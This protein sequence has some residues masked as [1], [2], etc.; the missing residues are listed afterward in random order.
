M[1]RDFEIR[2]L[3]AET[4]DAAGAAFED[5]LRPLGYR[6]FDAASMNAAKLS[7][8]KEAMRFF[9]CNYYDGDIWKYFPKGWPAGDAPTQ[10]LFERTTPFDYVELLR[11]SEQTLSTRFQLGIL[12]LYNVRRA[13]I[14]P[15]ST[16]SNL[17]FVT[18][19]M[20]GGDEES[21]ARTRDRLSIIASQLLNR[22]VELHKGGE[23]V[24]TT[25]VFAGLTAEET[26]CL[27]ALSRGLSNP[28]IAEALGVS[29]NT[30]RYHLKKVFRK[31][32]V[33]SRAEAASVAT[34]AGILSRSGGTQN[35]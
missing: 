27:A 26:T 17:Q 24:E 14:F 31:L 4:F 9:Y 7:S 30:V 34:A 13:W 35:G 1:K 21:F 20:I 23:V 19:Y 15:L 3:E 22:L 10:A 11:E 6:Y 28:E 25:S 18:V 5:E 33:S 16:P 12:N 2:L 32:G 29:A 8:P